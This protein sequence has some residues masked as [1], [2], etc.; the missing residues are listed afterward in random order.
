MVEFLAGLGLFLV[1]VLAGPWLDRLVPHPGRADRVRRR[2][3]RRSGDYEAWVELN[4]SQMTEELESIDEDLAGRG[5]SGSGPRL[6]MHQRIEQRYLW[7]LRNEW[8][9]M[10]ADVKDIFGELN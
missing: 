2:I 1:G 8:R 5:V 7:A 10:W 3:E 9:L 6:K 4:Y